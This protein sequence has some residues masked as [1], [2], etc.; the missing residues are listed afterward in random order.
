[1]GPKAYCLRTPFASIVSGALG[2]RI[3]QQFAV[4]ANQ[5]VLLEEKNW[6]RGVSSSGIGDN[7]MRA[8]HSWSDGCRGLGSLPSL[9]AQVE[10]RVKGDA[11]YLA[12]HDSVRSDGMTTINGGGRSTLTDLRIN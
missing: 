12:L 6:S 11:A 7:L 5:I 10:F 4:S 3:P 9:F 1:M 8:V 2:C